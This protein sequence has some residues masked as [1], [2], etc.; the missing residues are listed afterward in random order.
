MPRLNGDEASLII[1]DQLDKSQ[2]V[3]PF[4]CCVTSY[5]ERGYR[6]KALE[7]GMDGFLTKPI[8]KTGMQRLLLKS[9]ILPSTNC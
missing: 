1:R 5:Q 2:I 8:F 9:G 6:V 4:I 7:A 3:Q